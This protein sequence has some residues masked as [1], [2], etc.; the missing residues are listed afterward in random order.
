MI[1]IK[2]VSTIFPNLNINDW[3]CWTFTYFPVLP[4]P[5]YM[6]ICITPCLCVGQAFGYSP[7]VLFGCQSCLNVCI[8]LCKS[9]LSVYHNLAV[10]FFSLCAFSQ[11]L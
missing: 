11:E 4:P 10:D 5:V 2:A 3:F 9:V 1:A 8:A 6:K 7:Q